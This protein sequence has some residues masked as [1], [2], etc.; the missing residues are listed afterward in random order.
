M[1]TAMGNPQQMGHV[2]GALHVVRD[3]E[4]E[5][6]LEAAMARIPEAKRDAVV[7]SMARPRRTRAAIE[8]REKERQAA[9][10]WATLLERRVVLRAEPS[11][12]EEAKHRKR[13]A[14]DRR[15]VTSKF[16][17]VVHAENDNWRSST[18]VRIQTWCEK[19]SYLYIYIYI[20]NICIYIYIYV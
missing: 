4:R 6:I 18:A 15:R 8:T 10:L 9:G 14:D 2:I 12:D 13:I 17:P 7:T 3:A 20:L 19:G 11:L 1:G 16:G 5:D